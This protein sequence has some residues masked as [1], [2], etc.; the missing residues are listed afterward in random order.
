MVNMHDQSVKAENGSTNGTE[1]N[2]ESFD[3]TAEAV[4]QLAPKN[5]CGGI[6]ATGLFIA[7]YHQYPCTLQCDPP[8]DDIQFHVATITK[9][10]ASRF[11][12]NPAKDT[13]SKEYHRRT[14]KSYI[15]VRVANVTHGIMIQFCT[16]TLEN[17][18]QNPNKLP[19][20]H[21]SEYFLVTKNI[22][23]FYLPE[24][25]ELAEELSA[26]FYTMTVFTPTTCS[27]Q[28]VCR[29]QHGYYLSGIKIKK[30]VITDMALHYG[31]KFVGVHD[32]I[33]QSLN[34]KEGKGIVLLHGVPGSGKYIFL[35]LHDNTIVSII[36]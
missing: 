10:L 15:D 26:L 23:I 20:D 35:F 12:Y 1:A 33:I 28:M 29:N 36:D 21:A 3:Q 11:K 7:K 4:V 32:K 5:Y 25:D 14:K 24:Y 2:G 27:L 34:Q 6:P 8:S 19:V 16:C 31:Q 13:I 9:A 22:Q 17:E 30:P 18:V